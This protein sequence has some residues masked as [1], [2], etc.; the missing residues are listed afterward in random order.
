ML[1]L[2]KE[3]GRKDGRRRSWSS[4]SLCRVVSCCL[5]VSTQR[6]RKRRECCR[7]RCC[8]DVVVCVLGSHNRTAKIVLVVYECYLLLFYMLISGSVASPVQMYEQICEY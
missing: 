5:V 7:S 3:E 2:R 4:R 8:V 1:S 6:F